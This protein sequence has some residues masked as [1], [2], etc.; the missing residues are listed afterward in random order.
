MT[1]DG[2]EATLALARLVRQWV[3][4][5]LQELSCRTAQQLPQHEIY[6]LT[7]GAI[8]IAGIEYAH[9]RSSLHR[10]VCRQGRP[11]VLSAVLLAS[12]RIDLP[13]GAACSGRA[14]RSQTYM[15][16]F[17]ECRRGLRR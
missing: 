1:Q 5:H 9:L 6:N 4:R 16:E 15:F 10:I 13:F 17:R 12:I 7:A 3:R 11:K 2:A 8:M 14:F